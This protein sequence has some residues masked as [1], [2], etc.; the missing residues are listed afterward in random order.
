MGEIADQLP[1]TLSS[2]TSLLHRDRLTMMQRQAPEG[3]EL[4]RL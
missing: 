2:V 3:K 4:A 1:T